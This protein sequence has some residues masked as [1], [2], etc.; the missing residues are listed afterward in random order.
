MKKDLKFA[1]FLILS[2]LVIFLFSTYEAKMVQELQPKFLIMTFMIVGLVALISIF[3]Y[4]EKEFTIEKAFKYIIPII[5]CLF[6]IIMPI[7]RNHDEDSHWL[8]IY[9]ISNGNLIVPTKYGQYFKENASNY[10]ATKVPT[11]V[12]RIVN[13]ELTAGHNLQELYKFQIDEENTTFVSLQTECLYSPL[14]YIPQV[15]G[16]QI[17][18]LF[19]NRPLIMAYMARI[20]NMLFSITVLYFAIKL[21]PFGKK[22][23]LV[24]MSI[25]IAVEGFTSLSSDAM[26][27]SVSML[28][29]AYIFNIIF[30][31]NKEIITLKDKIILGVLALTIALCKIVYLPLVLLLVLLPKEKFK[32]SNKDKIITL[33]IIILIATIANLV[34]LYISSQYLAEWK[35][36]RSIIQFNKLISDPIGY[37][38]MVLHTINLYWGRYI[39]STFGGELGLN[40]HVLINNFTP[41]IFLILCVFLGLFDKDL[42]GRLTLFQII[43]IGLVIISI[44]GLIFTS[45]YLQWTPVEDTSIAGVQGRYFIPILP[46]LIFLLS[47]AKTSSEYSEDKILKF[48][49]IAILLT[50]INITMEILINNI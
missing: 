26:I 32:K 6:F 2:I 15:L 25:P 22:V 21:M 27:N 46:L 1:I 43:V 34:W 17:A 10:A 4:K 48:T 3:I 44:I 45:L 41:Y 13:R 9:D 36:G 8:R 38:E 31:K 18:K 33:I 49:C 40:E 19:T 16:V 50:Q 29:V 14:Q 42:K 28:F 37:V 30:N 5:F 24:V 7:F 11:A 20:V 47:K 12:F 23:F 35:D 39:N